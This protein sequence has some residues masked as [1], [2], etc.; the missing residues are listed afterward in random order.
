M[1][2][3]KEQLD[4]LYG[5][6]PQLTTVRYS[7]MDSF[8]HQTLTQHVQNMLML[9]PITKAHPSLSGHLFD[10][11]L[12]KAVILVHDLPELGMH[13]DIT[14]WELSRDPE[15]K[16]IK[17]KLEHE[18]IA[19]LGNIYGE[20]MP[21]LFEYYESQSDSLTKFVKWLDKYESNL[22]LLEKFEH[23]PD[24]NFNFDWIL[25]NTERMIIAANAFPPM[26]PVTIARMHEVKPLYE[27]Q[28]R[29]GLWEDLIEDLN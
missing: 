23:R 27:R 7:I 1:N 12:L 13:K 5:L 8:F 15:L 6:L 9:A 17:D 10:K 22:F 2:T 21:K 28:G 20:W 11:H 24:P 26:K 18:K 29:L 14:S 25:H 19:E 3:S 4:I 16:K